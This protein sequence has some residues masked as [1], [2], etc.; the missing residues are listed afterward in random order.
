MTLGASRRH[1][2]APLTTGRS[3]TVLSRSRGQHDGREK[4]VKRKRRGV[5]LGHRLVLARRF[6]PWA[7]QA[8]LRGRRK[9]ITRRTVDMASPAMTA[10]RP[11]FG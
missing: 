1:S 7:P 10:R 2:S 8:R 11:E 5:G 3:G 9:Q 4:P 6:L